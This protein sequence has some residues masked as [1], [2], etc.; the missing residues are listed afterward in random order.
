MKTDWQQDR[1]YQ[2]TFLDHCV[3]MKEVMKCQTVG[4]LIKED[5]E[6]IV[7]TSWRVVH[8]DKGMVDDNHEPTVIIKSTIKRAKLLR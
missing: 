5:P 2:I 8:E 3:G 1:L 7:L 6:Y 4:W